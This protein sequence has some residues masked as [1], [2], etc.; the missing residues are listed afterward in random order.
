VRGSISRSWQ[1]HG[2]Q[3]SLRMVLARY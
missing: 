3:E 2:F 1:L